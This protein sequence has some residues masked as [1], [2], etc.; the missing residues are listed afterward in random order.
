MTALVDAVAGAWSPREVQDAVRR[1]WQVGEL[2]RPQDGTFVLSERTAKET[3]QADRELDDAV[4]RVAERAR[5]AS[6]Q[7]EVRVRKVDPALLRAHCRTLPH[8]GHAAPGWALRHL[9]H[10][11]RRQPRGAPAT[12]ASTGTQAVAKRAGRMGACL[13]AL[14]RAEGIAGAHVPRMPQAP[15]RRL[16]PR[17]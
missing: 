10:P 4:R 15:A 16:Q 6:H 3:R 13:P 7:T 9:R 2:A 17:P 12:A 1:L 5:R 8:A 11:D 14:R